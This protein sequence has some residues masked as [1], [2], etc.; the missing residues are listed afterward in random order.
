[1]QLFDNIP[2]RLSRQQQ[3]AEIAPDGSNDGSKDP[4][5]GV[6]LRQRDA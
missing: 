6:W 4:G 1:M 2:F 5:Y 3:T